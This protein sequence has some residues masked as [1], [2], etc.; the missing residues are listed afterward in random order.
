MILRQ[1]IYHKIDAEHAYPVDDSTILLRLRSARMD[2][3]CA[4]VL[5]VDKYLFLRGEAAP[6]GTPMTKVANDE[7]FDYYEAL[8]PHEAT[9]LAYCFYLEAAGEQLYYGNYRFFATL[10]DSADV[11]YTPYMFIMPQIARDEIIKLPDWLTS[12]VVYQIFPD[13]FAPKSGQ[14]ADGLP[15]LDGGAAR[16]FG[17]TLGA[18][19]E[20]LDYLA[21]LGIDVIY[22]NPIFTAGGYHK[23]NTIDHFAVDP[24]FGNE[25]D[26]VLLVRKAH[27]RRM[28][29]VLDG[30]FS[31]TGVDFFAFRDLIEHG[32]ASAYRDWYEVKEFPVCV[33]TPPPYRTFGYH[34]ELPKLNFA[35]EEVCRYACDVMVHWVRLADIDGWR[36]DVAD[37]IPHSFWRRARRAIES[38]K[39]GVILVG[40][41]WYDST[42]WLAADQLDSVMNYLFYTN[43]VDFFAKGRLKPSAF[44][45]RMGALLATYRRP[46]LLG[47]WNLVG[48]HDT[49]RFLAESGGDLAR[50]RAAVAFQFTFP[51]VPV[52][53]YGD[54]VAMTGG[55]DPDCRGAM[56]WDKGAQ[57]HDVLNYY[58]KLA[59]A[60]RSSAAL[61][62]GSC[63][64]WQAHDA[65]GLLSFARR[66]GDETV[67]LFIHTGDS[68]LRV[69]LD[70]EGEDLLAAGG[71]VR[72]R[73]LAPWEVLIVRVKATELQQGGGPQP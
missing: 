24:Q 54:E 26:L 11:N 43:V 65:T 30:V 8:V 45:D 15:T 64:E 51:G 6:Q 71:T 38:V 33:V 4:T 41:V 67:R 56:I 44:A 28:R 7:L 37:E 59:A 39:P 32:E 25:E 12:A 20:R 2:L 69:T 29:V 57:N 63:I 49:A 36:L 19:S 60:R 22:L 62:R 5:S 3:Q 55:H 73:E 42:S 21:T 48:S 35:C 17:G 18:L 58:S 47:L 27:A 52:I 10:F 9:S 72:S 16:P 1:A 68:P 66:W 61:C 13:S 31:A 34:R 50:F 70:Q 14:W 23:Y 53:Y 46:F 40:E